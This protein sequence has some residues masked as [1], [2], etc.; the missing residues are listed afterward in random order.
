[1][2]SGAHDGYTV[3]VPLLVGKDQKLQE[4]GGEEAETLN[5]H[6]HRPVTGRGNTSFFNT[7]FNGLNALSGSSTNGFTLYVYMYK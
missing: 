4:L 2:D 1:M 5:S 3:T 6:G 7:C